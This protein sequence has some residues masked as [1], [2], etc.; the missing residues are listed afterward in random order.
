MATCLYCENPTNSEEHPLPVAFG[1][2]ED[3]PFYTTG[4]V[5]SVITLV[6]GCLTSSSLAA[7]PKPSCADSTE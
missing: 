6:L 4:F 2:F 7:A 5:L 1:E 3:A